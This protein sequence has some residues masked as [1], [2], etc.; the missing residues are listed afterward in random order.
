M[1]KR[2]LCKNV[3]NVLIETG[4]DISKTPYANCSRFFIDYPLHYLG[5]TNIVK[6]NDQKYSQEFPTIEKAMK[7]AEK[8]EKEHE[9]ENIVRELQ[10]CKK[11]IKEFKKKYGKNHIGLDDRLKEEYYKL[12]KI[13]KDLTAQKGKVERTVFKQ[14][15][16]EC[17]IDVSQDL[18]CIKARGIALCN[19]IE[20]IVEILPKLKGTYLN[21]NSIPI[22]S[23]NLRAFADRLEDGN[24]AIEGGP[25]IIGVDEVFFCLVYRNDQ[26][27]YFDI[28]T[29]FEDGP[30]NTYLPQ[31]YDLVDIIARDRRDIVDI[32]IHTKHSGPTLQNA[33]E[34]Y[35]LMLIAKRIDIPLVISLPDESYKKQLLSVMNPLRSAD[36]VSKELHKLLY[37]IVDEFLNLI[38]A[39]N[40]ILKLEKLE[41]LHS[42]NTKLIEVFYQKRSEVASSVGN[43]T[44]IQVKKEAIID[45]ICLPAVPNFIW[46]TNNI[47]E[48]N[49]IMEL[50]SLKAAMKF[51]PKIYFSALVFPYIPDVHNHS[52]MYH[53]K[54]RDKVF[55]DGQYD[56]KIISDNKLNCLDD[57]IIAQVPWP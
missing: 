48:V 50:E 25:C 15:R 45:Y 8:L 43:I 33:I 27:R 19:T 20:D 14:I 16:K 55:L 37:G 5:L 41:V 6:I 22:F 53:G 3:E 4:T 11:K 21:R 47:L 28:M 29:G 54:S 32:E 1:I 46:G 51:F 23:Y 44:D 17:G 36:K 10:E 9:L 2:M 18:K 13:K 12:I 30:K 40:Q 34:L 24:S 7:K 56:M 52:S 35:R 26:R 39:I 38:A 49:N 57:I 42:R 31:R